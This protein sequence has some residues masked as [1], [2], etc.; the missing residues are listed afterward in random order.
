M[1][2]CR[3]LNEIKE[4]EA[5]LTECIERTLYK[6]SKND[7]IDSDCYKKIKE[8]L[9]NENVIPNGDCPFVYRGLPLS[10]CPCYERSEE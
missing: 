4:K 8:H 3:F 1:G 5:V 10:E 7:S 6:C 2:E 9:R